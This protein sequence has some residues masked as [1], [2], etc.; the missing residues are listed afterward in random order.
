MAATFLWSLTT[1]TSEEDA[2]FP[3]TQGAARDLA[4]LVETEMN[5]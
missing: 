4:A 5:Y 3:A 1:M 2:S